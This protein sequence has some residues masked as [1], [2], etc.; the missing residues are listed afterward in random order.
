MVL[1]FAGIKSRYNLILQSRKRCE[2]RKI[3]SRK[4]RKNI[5]EIRD[6]SRTILKQ[7]RTSI[8]TRENLRGGGKY[9]TQIKSH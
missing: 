1:I 8:K 7:T 5:R 9:R 6:K 4:I 2:I 3:K